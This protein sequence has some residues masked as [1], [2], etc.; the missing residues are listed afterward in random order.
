MSTRS[1]RGPDALPE[2]LAGAR[3]WSKRRSRSWGLS[4][5]FPSREA[6]TMLHGPLPVQAD[7]GREVRVLAIV[8]KIVNDVPM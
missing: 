5:C 2:S 8:R 6:V 7:D 1:R 3:H 4:A